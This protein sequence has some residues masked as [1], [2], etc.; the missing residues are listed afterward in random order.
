MFFFTILHD[1]KFSS[2]EVTQKEPANTVFT[3]MKIALKHY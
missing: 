3:G 2:R 1:S